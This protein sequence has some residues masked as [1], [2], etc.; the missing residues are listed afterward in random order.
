LIPATR[1][2]AASGAQNAKVKELQQERLAILH[3]VA[4]LVKQVHQHGTGSLDQVH[5]ANRMVFDA[6][7]ELAATERERLA[8]LE[9]IVAEAKQHE[10]YVLQRSKLGVAPPTAPLKAKAGRLEAEIALERARV[11]AAAP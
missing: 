10:E 2:S 8:V 11:K 7:L 4:T 9:K 6:E 5:Q 1:A 3:E